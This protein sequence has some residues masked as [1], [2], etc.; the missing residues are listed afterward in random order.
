MVEQQ[1]TKQA[2]SSQESSATAKRHQG[3][4]MMQRMMD[5]LDRIFETLNPAMASGA[6]TSRSWCPPI[7][8]VERDGALVVSADL[9]GL[10]RDDV[11]GELTPEGL[12]I[13]GERKGLEGQQKGVIR[14]ERRYGPFFRLIPLPGGINAEQVK[15]APSATEY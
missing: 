12:L 7:E 5:D 15:R 4:V 9:P 1:Q 13:Q 14:S 11:K 6:V 2:G 8:V 3:G 10:R